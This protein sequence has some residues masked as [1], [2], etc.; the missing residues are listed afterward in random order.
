MSKPL[1]EVDDL[2]KIFDVS[3][4][5]LN[6]VV[7]RKP[8]AFV[9]AVDGVSFSIERGKTLVVRFLTIGE[10]DDDGRR[11]IFFELNGQPRE[12]KVVDRS[13]A[14]TG[15]VR[16]MADEGDPTHVPAPMPGL[17]VA[18]LA[19]EGDRVERG[20]RLL[21]IEAM[22]METAL[23]AERDGKIAEVLVQAGSQ[24]DAKDLLVVYEG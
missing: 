11:T 19:H 3:P 2:A 5:W 15:P 1:V 9:H 17:V 14:P 13:V 20:D 10:A 8:K 23:H 21:S 12:V 24:I 18:V 16:R 22:K 7:E 6:R 4:P